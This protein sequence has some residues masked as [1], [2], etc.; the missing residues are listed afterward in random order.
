MGDPGPPQH[1]MEWEQQEWEQQQQQP[2]L[3]YGLETIQPGAVRSLTTDKLASFSLGGTKK[4]PYQV[5]G[6]GS[7]GFH[8]RARRRDSRSSAWLFARTEAEGSQ[9]GQATQRGTGRASG[10]QH[11]G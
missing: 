2:V 11:V 6:R 5:F 10:A 9:R 1:Q 3:P 8:A 4:T 7:L